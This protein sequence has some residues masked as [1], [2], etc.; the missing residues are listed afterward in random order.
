MDDKALELVNDMKNIMILLCLTGATHASV[1]CDEPRSPGVY[2]EFADSEEIKSITYI[3]QEEPET[4]PHTSEPAISM[5]LEKT[6]LK[7]HLT[8][9]WSGIGIFFE[10]EKAMAVLPKADKPPVFSFFDSNE[11]DEWVV[12]KAY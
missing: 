8:L 9:G 6:K 3:T 7:Y 11:E 1:E 4:A 2:Y 12:L 5:I 10:M